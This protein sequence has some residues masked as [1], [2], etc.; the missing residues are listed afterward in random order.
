MQL[1]RG[2]RISKTEVHG[3]KKIAKNRRRMNQEKLNVKVQYI[4]PKK[5]R[6]VSVEKR[7]LEMSGGNE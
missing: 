4:Q 1:K 7:L 5:C 3:Y 2:K 6:K